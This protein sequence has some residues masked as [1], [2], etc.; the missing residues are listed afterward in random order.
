[1]RSRR[2]GSC[3]AAFLFVALGWLIT[4][5]SS[6]FAHDA[7]APRAGAPDV[8]TGAIKVME[9]REPDPEQPATS[10]VAF[11]VTGGVFAGV[12]ALSLATGALCTLDFAEE[13]RGLCL[14][15]TTGAGGVSMGFGIALIAAGLIDYTASDRATAPAVE[16]TGAPGGIGLRARF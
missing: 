7:D 2:A 10:G 5:P 16:V 4:S 3:L 1:M 6:A 14:G 12:G 9:Y 15:L 8:P 11:L 13:E